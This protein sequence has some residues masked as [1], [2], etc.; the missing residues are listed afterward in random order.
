MRSYRDLPQRFAE[1]GTCYRYEQ[2]GE[3]SGLLRVRCMTMNDAHIYVREDQLESELKSIIQMY[4][5]FYTTFK[6]TEY[7][8]RLS[9]IGEENSD[10]FIGDAAVW[11]R[12]ENLLQKALDE[13]KLDYFVGKGEAAFYGPKIDIQ[14]KNLMGRE[15]TVS[16]IQVDFQSPLN[17]GLSYIDDQGKEARPVIIHRSP[18]STHERFLS[19]LLEYYGGAFPAWCAPVQVCVVPVAADY[20][21]YGNEL[22]EEM[23]KNYMRVE[24]DDSN[25]S[26]NKRIRTNTVRKIPIMLIVG[27]KEAEQQTV[28][29]RRYGMKDQQTMPRTE[30]MAMVKDE[31]AKRLMLREPMGSIV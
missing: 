16:T 27:Q 14:F 20:N 18:L 25:N 6:F 4:Q 26:F 10:K 19:F 21:A 15:E 28:T 9:V 31:I 1:Y 2:S 12:A 22:L 23:R 11:S 8:Y 30:F 5:E 13:M 17:F 29:V 7:R 24:L 3:L